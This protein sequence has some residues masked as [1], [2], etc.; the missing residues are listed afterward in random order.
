MVVYRNTEITSWRDFGISHMETPGCKRA[1]QVR[2][3]PG[4]G[5]PAAAGAGTGPWL[6]DTFGPVAPGY[7]RAVSGG[8]ISRIRDSLIL[9]TCTMVKKTVC[10][11]CQPQLWNDRLRE[12][13]TPCLKAATSQEFLSTVQASFTKS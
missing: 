12:E 2:N 6:E 13:V 5:S 1:S 11:L 3:D 10:S 7:S 4:I 9:P 8:E